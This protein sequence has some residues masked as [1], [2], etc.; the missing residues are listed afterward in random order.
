MSAVPGRAARHWPTPASCG[1]WPRCTD[2]NPTAQGGAGDAAGA[3]RGRRAGHPGGRGSRR[4]HRL[5]DRDRALGGRRS[6]AVR[7]LEVRRHYGRSLGRAR[8]HQPVDHLARG[9]GGRPGSSLH[10]GRHHRRRRHRTGRRPAPDRPHRR[11]GAGQPA[12]VAGHRRHRRSYSRQSPG[13]RRR[14]PY[15]HRDRGRAGL[16]CG[17]SGRP[18][19]VR[20]GPVRAWLPAGAAGGWTDTGRRLPARRPGRRGRRLHGAQ[21]ARAP[22]RPRWPRP[23]SSRSP[24][25]STWR[26][27]TCD[28]SDPTCASTRCRRGT[29]RV[30]RNRRG[31][32]RGRRRW[33]GTAKGPCSACAVR[34]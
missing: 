22:D 23:A 29:S 18:A 1:W 17:R 11:R 30:H 15:L 4:Q 2:P 31:A 24:R 25:R 20:P 28:V 14:G 16:R 10:C 12:T 19:P 9:A 3:R 13:P 5:A 8:R 6:S 7:H 32:G 26:S 34:P 27:P 21:A 33:T